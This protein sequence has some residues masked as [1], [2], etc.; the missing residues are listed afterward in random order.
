[1]RDLHGWTVVLTRAHEDNVEAASWFARS[2]AAVLEL[3]CVRMEPLRDRRELDAALSARTDAEWVVVTSRHGADALASRAL[4]RGPVAA[5]GPVT[6]DRLRASGIAVDFVPTDATGECLATEL[7]RPPDRAL[8]VRSDRALPDLPAALRRRG[9]VV[10][11]A[12][13]YRTVAGVGGDAGQVRALLERSHRSVAVA[14]WSPSALDAL[15]H[16]VG[17]D[18]LARALL[19]A[20]GPTT[21]RAAR[22]LLGPAALIERLEME[23]AHVAHR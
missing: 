20:I 21:E 4:V 5:V 11:E 10:R 2:G 18:V 22:Q 16:T 6:A 19:L 13:A 1:M 14:L 3:P 8:L 9:F 15:V 12:I 7:P 23:N 17:A